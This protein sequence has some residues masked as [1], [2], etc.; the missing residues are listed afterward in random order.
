MAQLLLVESDDSQRKRFREFLEG[1]G[2]T[3]AAFSSGDQYLRARGSDV[4]TALVAWELAGDSTGA[5]VARQL[6]QL[7]PAS[8]V[9]FLGNSSAVDQIYEARRLGVQDW[10]G[11]GEALSDL[12][13]LIDKIT[14]KEEE[15]STFRKLQAP[16]RG[17]IGDSLRWRRVLKD[18]AFALDAGPNTGILLTG[19]TG[20]GKG[21]LAKAVKKY[22]GINGIEYNLAAANEQV[23]E[24]ALFGHVEGAFTDA[25]RRHAGLFEEVGTGILFLDEFCEFPYGLQAKLLTVIEERIFHPVGGSEPQ[26]FN[27][28]LILATNRDLDVAVADRLLR[29]DLY[30][31]IATWNVRIPALAERHNDWKLLTDYWLERYS[32]EDD[33]QLVLSDEVDSY[34]ASFHF[35]GNVRQLQKAIEHAVQ[36]AAG[37]TIQFRDLPDTVLGDG[38]FTSEGKPARSSSTSLL[39]TLQSWQMPDEMA[40]VPYKELQALCKDAIHQTVL[41]GYLEHHLKLNRWHLT[42]TAEAI[43][44]TDKTL[45]EGLQRAGIELERRKRAP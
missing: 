14:R 7:C 39:E 32:E 12:S 20:C 18:L 41:R 40:E 27:G 22:L 13:A 36:R 28:R 15:A 9:V 11:Y 35:E 25:R 26:D 19:P 1:E 30:Q 16:E 43:G 4:D 23:I 44:V 5:F 38:A 3:V 31:R 33:R 6:Q 10:F 2:H 45:R 29:Y 34:F 21:H 24:S 37:S 17:L 8:E 42:N